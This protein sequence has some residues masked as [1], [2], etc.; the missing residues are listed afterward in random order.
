M[1][2]LNTAAQESKKI[3]VGTVLDP[4]RS[5]AVANIKL[6]RKAVQ[7]KDNAK[8]EEALTKAIELYQELKAA[9]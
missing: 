1:Q 6:A 8:A 7:D 2:H 5:K 4:K 9:L 3:E